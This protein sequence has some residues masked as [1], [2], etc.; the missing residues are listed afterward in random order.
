MSESREELLQ[1]LNDKLAVQ[2]TTQEGR[3]L[4]GLMY[5]TVQTLGEEIDSLEEQLDEME[6]QLE[7]VE[8]GDQ[9]RKWYSER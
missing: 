5:A 1:K 2:G 8:D 6:K 3:E 7:E 4:V 9:S